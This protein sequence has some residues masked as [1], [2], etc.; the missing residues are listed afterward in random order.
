ML[1]VL[2]KFME[3]FL[4]NFTEVCDMKGKIFGKY[5]IILL[6][7]EFVFRDPFCQLMMNVV[8]LAKTQS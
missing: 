1:S 6:N 7:P 5:T 4:E 8:F 2:K 3:S